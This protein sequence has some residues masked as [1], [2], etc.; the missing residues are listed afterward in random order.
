MRRE[1]SER[2]AA[3]RAG[4]TNKN[5]GDHKNTSWGDDCKLF[6]LF[7]DETLEVPITQGLHAYVFALTHGLSGFVISLL[8]NQTYR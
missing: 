8:L 2:E 6:V 5:N 7:Q 4:S 3:H 1:L